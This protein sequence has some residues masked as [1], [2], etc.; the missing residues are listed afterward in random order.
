[1]KRNS[2]LKIS[3]LIILAL[4]L[5]VFYAIF[6]G[7]EQN[8]LPDYYSY[9]YMFETYALGGFFVLEYFFISEFFK[10]LSLL[11]L[12]YDSSR[13]LFLTI[14]LL[15]FNISIFRF[16]KKNNTA[17]LGNISVSLMMPLIITAIVVFYFEFFTIRLRGGFCIILFLC[18]L[19][20]NAKFFKILFFLLGFITHPTTFIVLFFLNFNL[21]FNNFLSFKK[22]FYWLIISISL[23]LFFLNENITN[24]RT[25]FISELNFFRVIV[26]YLLPS[27]LFLILHFKKGFTEQE[28]NNLAPIIVLYVSI[29]LLHFTNNTNLMGEALVRISTLSSFTSILLIFNKASIKNF[30]LSLIILFTNCLFF[31]NT[32][33]WI[34]YEI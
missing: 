24:I 32:I 16:S 11:G 20:F 13:I 31:L 28:F 18:Y 6:I 5:I 23:I 4:S 12:N 34:S 10:N 21:Q 8:R 30:Y 19:S 14:S 15:I 25:D 22:H 33:G 29:I 17:Q 9:E 1:M 7:I 26:S 3:L 27:L 2:Y